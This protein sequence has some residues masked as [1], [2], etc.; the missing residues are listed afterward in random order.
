MEDMNIGTLIAV[1]E[2]MFGVWLFWG[3][4]ALA[5]LI[6]LLFFYVLVR[7]RG[8]ESRRLVRAELVAPLGAIGAILF[9]Q[10]ITNSGFRDVG[11]PIDWIVLLGI[12]V[13]GAV[14]LMLLVYVVQA[15]LGRGRTVSTSR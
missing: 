2:E 4:F 12:G 3:L 1:F 7:D 15:I 6:T 14:G 5:A 9:V 10:W 13:A 8:L 11:G